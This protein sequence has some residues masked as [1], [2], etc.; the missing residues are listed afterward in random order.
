MRQ[1]MYPPPPLDLPVHQ[2]LPDGPVVDTPHRERCNPNIDPCLVSTS[3]QPTTQPMANIVEPHTP[4]RRTQVQLSAP[5]MAAFPD[6]SPPTSPF[7][8]PFQTPA[9]GGPPPSSCSGSDNPSPSPI[10][11]RRGTKAKATK[12]DYGT[13]EI[14]AGEEILG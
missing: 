8:D 9:R 13:V 7:S 10:R 11:R 2:A 3:A 6:S 5:S 1:R 12:E 4:L 14:M